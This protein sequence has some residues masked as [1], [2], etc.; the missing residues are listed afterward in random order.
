MSED[1]RKA[2]YEG[3]VVFERTPMGA[4]KAKFPDNDLT[5]ISAWRKVEEEEG[6]EVQINTANMESLRADIKILGHEPLPVSGFGRALKRKYRGL[7]DPQRVKIPKEEL[8]HEVPFF[9][10]V[11]VNARKTGEIQLTRFRGDMEH[12]GIK[13]GQGYVV[14]WVGTDPIRPDWFI[15]VLANVLDGLRRACKEFPRTEIDY[16]KIGS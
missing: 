16:D 3:Y 1:Q 5:L 8:Y 14:H 2:L 15:A 11:D 9:L 13:H 12:L 4:V 7:P 10:V 6:D